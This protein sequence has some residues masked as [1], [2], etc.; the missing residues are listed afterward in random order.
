VYLDALFVKSRQDPSP[1]V[2]R[3]Q[4]AQLVE[5]RQLEATTRRC[6]RLESHLRGTALDES[7]RA[8]ECFED[9]WD[10]HF[11][12]ISRSWRADWT[13]LTVMFDYPPPIRKVIYTTNAIESLDYSP[14][15]VLKQRGSFPNNEAITKVLYLALSRIAK[16]WTMPITNWKAALNQFVIMFEDRVIL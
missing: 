16:K 12:A 3:A 1:V 8:L 9:T 14:R 13:R 5:V 4:G 2:H 15:K 11:P 7:Q 10:A 6:R